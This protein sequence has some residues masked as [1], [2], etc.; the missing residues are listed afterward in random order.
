MTTGIKNVR[1]EERPNT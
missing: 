1:K